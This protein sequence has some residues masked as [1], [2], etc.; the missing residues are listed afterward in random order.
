M[1]N[2]LVDPV[3]FLFHRTNV[4]LQL[5]R[6]QDMLFIEA[7]EIVKFLLLVIYLVLDLFPELLLI[8]CHIVYFDVILVGLR[9]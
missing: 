6:D 2:F 4:P 9:Y 8:H 1:D 5:L 7:P 3:S